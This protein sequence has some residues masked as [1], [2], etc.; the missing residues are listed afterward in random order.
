[1][2]ID[3]HTHIS[4]YDYNN[5]DEVIQNA[6][7]N[8][9]KYLI[10]SCCS[11]NTINEGLELIEKYNNIFLTIGLHPEE[12]NNYTNNDLD[13][14][15][16]LAK[17]TKKIVGIGEIGLDYHYEKDSKNQ[18]IELFEKQL[19]IAKEL[20]MP[21]V[22]HTRDAT[23]DTINILS[24]HNLKGIIHCFNGSKETLK[25]Y[26]DMGYYIGIGGVITFKN[27]NLGYIIKDL[28]INKIMLETD[29]PYLTPE[30]YR[31]TKNE[32]KNI[33]IIAKK[34]SEIKKISLE[35]VEKNTSQNAIRLFNLE[36]IIYK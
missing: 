17:N 28:D 27:S 1:M 13:Y 5:I 11:V 29:S 7:N 3:S 23:L 18:Q 15:R 34:L 14:I 20:N 36:K 22:I 32:S 2:Y 9:V 10:V 4:K 8:N 21:I 33:P 30:P 26:I 12:I 19:R 16:K 6:L 25:K 35:E 31:G 24:K